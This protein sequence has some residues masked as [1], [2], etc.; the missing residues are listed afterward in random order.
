MESAGCKKTK[1]LLRRQAERGTM[2]SRGK[3]L[4]IVSHP[5]QTLMAAD[6]YAKLRHVAAQMMRRERRSHTLQATAVVHEAY[7]RLARQACFGAVD[8]AHFLSLAAATI[9]RVLLDHARRSA[10]QRRGARLQRTRFAEALQP[11]PE[12]EFDPLIFEEALSRLE[13]RDALKAQIVQLRFF[14]G[15]PMQ[16]IAHALR[17]S[18]RTVAHEWEFARAWLRREL[19]HEHESDPTSGGLR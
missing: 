12:P 7:L 6:V 15:L 17:V 4:H 19:S 1:K 18:E 14:V 5:P 2:R 11:A 9:R 10:A 8:G 3:E 16:E 13:R